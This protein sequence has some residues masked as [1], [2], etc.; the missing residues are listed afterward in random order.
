[1]VLRWVSAAAVCDVNKKAI[2][3]GTTSRGDWIVKI[4][5]AIDW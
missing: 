1:M 2:V 3:S 5:A 4:E